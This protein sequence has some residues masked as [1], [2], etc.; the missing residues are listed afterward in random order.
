VSCSLGS[1]R[2]KPFDKSQK[3]QAAREIPPRPFVFLGIEKSGDVWYNTGSSDLYPER[4]MSWKGWTLFVLVMLGI[5]LLI[6][7]ESRSQT[8]ARG[9]ARSMEE[10][11][12]MTSRKDSTRMASAKPSRMGYVVG[13][14]PI[15]IVVV[16]LAVGAGKHVTEPS[17]IDFRS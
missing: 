14:L 5:A 11:R 10:Q 17:E 8:V 3:K 4:H 16:A 6:P 12:E 9:N 1:G 15:V 2:S 13:T 7:R